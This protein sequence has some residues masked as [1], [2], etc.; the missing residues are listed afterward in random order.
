MT[1][2][3][4]RF[5]VLLKG[6][7]VTALSGGALALTTL[8][9]LASSPPLTYLARAKL[10][11][12]PKVILDEAWQIVDSEY[13]DPTFNHVDWQQVRQ[14]LLSQNYSSREQAYTALR[15]ALKQLNDPY[16]RFLD[17]KEFQ[18]LN[19]ETQ[20][21]LTGVGIQL[22]VD[23]QTQ[24]LTVVKPIEN[25]PALRAGVQAG[26]QILEIDGRSTKGMSLEDSA[27]LIRGKAHTTVS[28][29]LER[30]NRQP[31]AL[32]LT[33][34]QIEV[35]S[36]SSALR[37][38]GQRRIG[39]IRLAEFDNHAAEQM[40]QAIDDLKKQ[41]VDGFVLDL[42]D[43]P[44]GLVKQAVSIAQ[45]WLAQG[46]IVRTVDRN[47][48]S[49]VVKAN[50]TALT[51][52]PLAVLVNGDSASASE[53]LTGALKDN[54]RAIIVGTQTFGKALVQAVNPLPD[55]SGVNVTI[56]HYFTPAG[57][58]INHRGITP[59]VNISLT[60]QQAQE[61]S[62]HPDTIGT[63]SDLQY[64]QAV[65]HLKNGIAIAPNR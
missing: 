21:E 45:M 47:S 26:D 20:G 63:A 7:Y 65:E 35:P 59:D 31:F 2:P 8:V 30:A 48:D 4:R 10:T 42:R 1:Q 36:V 41:N 49:S 61:L 13:V 37:I 17:P 3:L 43:N 28:L 64:E 39:Y 6:F 50:N 23:K 11:D 51:N 57:T 5:P 52:L 54:H 40:H 27:N 46:T 15:N 29:L 19:S 24:A 25:S 32:T 55:G 9:A 16:T 34:E 44:G 58:D 14:H 56:E 60:K 12:S 38:D 53:I 18:A 62:E 33:R 22:A